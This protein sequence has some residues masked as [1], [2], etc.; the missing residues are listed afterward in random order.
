MEC[1]H[2]TDSERHSVG[3]LQ[4]IDISL[5]RGYIEEFAGRPCSQGGGME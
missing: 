5:A 3:T 2:G 1:G 4:D